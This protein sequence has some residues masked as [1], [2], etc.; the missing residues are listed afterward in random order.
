MIKEDEG[1]GGARSGVAVGAAAG[2]RRQALPNIRA[3]AAVNV[4]LSF[5]AA[6]FQL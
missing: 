1:A 3:A 5:G 2:A 6:K 4:K